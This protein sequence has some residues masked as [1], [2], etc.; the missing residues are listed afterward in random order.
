MDAADAAAG[1]AG[2]DGSGSDRSHYVCECDTGYT[3]THCELGKL[4]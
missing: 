3:G 4:N 2:G 1:G